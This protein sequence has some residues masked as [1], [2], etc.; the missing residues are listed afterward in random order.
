[1]WTTCRD[2]KI[3]GL[4]FKTAWKNTSLCCYKRV[5]VTFYIKHDVALTLIITARIGVNH[6]AIVREIPHFDIFPAFLLERPTFFNE[7]REEKII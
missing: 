7:F 6:P 5:Y 1:M 2:A 4:V 3:I